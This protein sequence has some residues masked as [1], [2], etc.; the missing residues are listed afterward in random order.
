M[1]LI[2]G[3]FEME[4]KNIKILEE[5]IND[6]LFLFKYTEVSNML[7]DSYNPKLTVKVG[8]RIDKNISKLLQTDDGVLKLKSLLE[9]ND[10]RLNFVAARYLYP[11]DPSFYSTILIKY[12]ESLKEKI[13]ISEIETLISGLEKR[14]KVFVDQYKNLYG[15]NRFKKLS[16]ME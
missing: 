10:I 11:L 5:V 14:Q 13:R 2:A 15:E 16:R 4:D 12:K 6:E 8:K 7:K 3:M 1:A 9:K